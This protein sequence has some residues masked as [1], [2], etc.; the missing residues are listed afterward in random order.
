MDNSTKLAVT[1]ISA[2]IFGAGV[3]GTITFFITKRYF[4]KK[5]DEEI[6]NQTEYYMLKYDILKEDKDG[7]CIEEKGNDEEQP[8]EAS[9]QE[10]IRDISSLYKS[11]A[12]EE[13]DKVSY[14]SYFGNDGSSGDDISTS[15][16][17]KKKT[18]RKSGPKLVDETI[19]NT[20]PD[21]FEK[22]F[23][24][25]YDADGVM[26]D[27]ETEK[28]VEN[29]EELVGVAN[30]DQA[31]QFDDVIFVSNSKTKTIYQVTVEQMA[32]SEVGID[33]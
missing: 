16:T 2:F 25:Y 12:P 18:T 10:D 17:T 20:N 15:K 9:I 33:D 13:V 14:G 31:D 11:K 32:F 4:K 28:I 3:S 26:V 7:T 1:G 6:M 19:W 23:F 22:K 27:D 29:G 30:L 5:C 8:K 21:N 24:I